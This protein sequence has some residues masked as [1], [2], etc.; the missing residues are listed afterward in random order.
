MNTL[1]FLCS[2]NLCLPIVQDIDKIRLF[3]YT[4]A[5]SIRKPIP[6]HT[7][8]VKE[9]DVEVVDRTDIKDANVDDKLV[10]SFIN[11][12]KIPFEVRD[13]QKSFVYSMIKSRCLMLSPTDP[14][15]SDNLSDAKDLI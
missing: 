12:L 10:D 5:K 4:N 6:I 13:Y 1:H 8:L 15:I 7:K 2:L 9:N 3:S 14:K 11:K